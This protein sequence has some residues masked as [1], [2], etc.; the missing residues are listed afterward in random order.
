MRFISAILTA[1]LVVT[2][3]AART[4]ADD[5]AVRIVF[6][7]DI[8]LDGGPGHIVTTGGDPF[9]DVATA[10]S[11]GDVT[12]GNLECAIVK[13]GHAVDKPYTF[14]GPE[15]ALPLLTKHFTAMSLANNHSGDWGKAGFVTELELLRQARLPFFGGG[16]NAREA[17]V[18]LILT[19]KGR[20]IALLGYNDFPPQ[21]FA[22]GPA[23]PGTAWLVRKDVV[24][25]IQAARKSA[26]LVLL[27][28]HW[29]EDLD[30]AHSAEQQAMAH[31]FIDAGADAIIGGHAHLTQTVEWYKNR[32]IVY[33]LGNFVFDYFPYDPPKWTGWIVKLTFATD[34]RPT[35]DIIPV[36]LDAAG[37]PHLA[38]K[39]QL[40]S[41]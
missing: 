12:V 9:A 38:P 1:G 10:L 21:S 18:P 41:N 19:V 13:K 39:A 22:A 31:A 26:D 40:G 14:R 6:A 33:C 34:E 15:R 36:E 7:G 25:D 3:F 35:L 5:Q 29:G 24:R 30:E 8:M 32:P 23:T 37:I 11:D 4:R 27:Y 28:L 20:K 17:R 16:M 2:G